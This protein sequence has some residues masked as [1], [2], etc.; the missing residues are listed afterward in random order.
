MVRN[1]E[2]KTD[3]EPAS[4]VYNSEWRDQ[5]TACSRFP[6][7]SPSIFPREKPACR[8][9]HS[10]VQRST[11]WSPSYHTIYEVYKKHCRREQTGVNRKFI[12]S[13]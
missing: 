10:T 7:S 9:E 5:I 12:A 11:L 13:Q 8:P 2:K 1:K 4:T 3:K 6:F